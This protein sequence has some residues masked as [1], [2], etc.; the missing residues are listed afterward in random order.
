MA[1]WAAVAL[2][3]WVRLGHGP[4]NGALYLC[5]AGVALSCLLAFLS[6]RSCAA[7]GSLFLLLGTTATSFLIAW[8]LREASALLL[9]VPAAVCAGGVLFPAASLVW[10]ALAAGLA[11]LLAGPDQWLLG[12]H[13]LATGLMAW[14]AFGP[15]RSLLAA[16]WQRSQEV[17]GLMDQLRRER[18][19]LNKTIKSLDL[20]YQLLEKSH[21][22]LAIAR[23]EAE[24]LREMRDRFAI[25]VSHE[26]RTPLNI[27]LG[28]SSLIY[29]NPQLY[30]FTRWPDSLLRDLAQIQR[31]ARHLSELVDDVIDLARVDALAMPLRREPMALE[32]VIREA[33]QSITSMAEEKGLQLAVDC[34]E[35]LPPVPIDAL[36]IRQVLYNL[37]S[38]A[39]RFTDRGSVEVQ[40]R[41]NE[42]EVIV[43]VRDTGRGIPKEELEH[44]FDEFYQVGR[45]KTLPETG[46]GL[47]LAIARRLVQLHGGRIWAQSE[48]GVGS[49]FF[50][51][52]PLSPV[53]VSRLRSTSA[54]GPLPPLRGRPVVAVLGEDDTPCLYLARRLENYD[55]VL[56][57]DSAELVELQQRRPVAA[58][59]ADCSTENQLG[60]SACPVPLISCPLP[61]AAWL[62]AGGMFR[63]VL[64]KP[65]TG[66]ELLAALEKALPGAGRQPRLLI[67][68]DDR[69]FVELVRRLLQAAERHFQ[70]EAAYD[71]REALEK[72]RRRPPDCVLLDLVLPEL[73]GLQVAAE[74]QADAAM[75][76][77]PVIAVTAAT[78]GEDRLQAEGVELRLR[79]PDRFRPGELTALLGFLFDLFRE[80]A[81]ARAGFAA[82]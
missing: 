42:G 28:F 70:L 2:V 50:F 17:L 74:M 7:L 72:M 41:A 61:S 39:I 59:I 16:S 18:G 67:V 44:I 32:P 26:L 47:G 4:L 6:G 10:G 25:N 36:R 73:S 11:F 37:L 34:E 62:S 79:L 82:P 48:P 23:R 31:N 76:A 80:R 1:A 63:A 81:A 12:S 68:D 57:R 69:G 24:I 35:G 21:R 22:E 38:N 20:A 52:L 13:F 71:G 53:A 66:D 29:R 51:T 65:I 40:A 19:E 14:A 60:L 75:S 77:I 3:L 46:K 27:V 56:V 49:T 5:A 15:Q 33:V 54:E 30:G 55:F 8:L 58:A 45:P 64:T 9:L 78:P 43:A